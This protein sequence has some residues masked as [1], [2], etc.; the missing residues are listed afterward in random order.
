[1]RSHLTQVIDAIF[2]ATE[3]DVL[4]KAK[5]EIKAKRSEYAKRAL[6]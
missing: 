6:I 2:K 5:S 1:M 3:L 4:E